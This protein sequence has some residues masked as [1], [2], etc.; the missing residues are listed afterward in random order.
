MTPDD[1]RAVMARHGLTQVQLAAAMHPP[2]H[3]ST[4]SRW[5]DGSS[6]ERH[7]RAQLQALLDAEPDSVRPL[8]D[9]VVQ[10]WRDLLAAAEAS[11]LSPEFRAA[12]DRLARATLRTL[13]QSPEQ[14]NP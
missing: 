7:H 10:S 13:G 3:Q 14:P 1:I 11:D 4:V 2:V 6:P 8:Q 5:L 12:V 9:E